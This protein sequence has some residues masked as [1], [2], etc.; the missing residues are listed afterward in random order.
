M[1]DRRSSGRYG[2]TY[3]VTMITSQGIKKGETK[4]VSANGAFIACE[5]PLD[6]RDRVCLCIEFR[7][8][9]LGRWTPRWSGQLLPGPVRQIHHE[10][11]AFVFCGEGTPG[12][13]SVFPQHLVLDRTV[14]TAAPM[15]LYEVT[16]PMA[17]ILPNSI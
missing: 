3:P 8:G 14:A 1:E 10:G 12:R 2:T 4:N 6:P 11:W 15:M 16:C 9:A 7:S 5:D 17:R 13:N